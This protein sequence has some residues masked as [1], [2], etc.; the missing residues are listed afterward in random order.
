MFALSARFSTSPFFA[1]TSP[2]VRGSVFSAMAQKIYEDAV[3]L[4]EI[5]NC[6]F[7]L[8]QGC[9]LL[10]FYYQTSRP[11][12]TSWM[13]IGTCC[14]IAIELGLNKLDE[15]I[16]FAPQDAQ[17]TSI[18]EWSQKEEKRR[19]WWLVWE[20]DVFSST[21]LR[22]P[23]TID[24]SQMQVLLPVSDAN[25]LANN[26]VASAAFPSDPLSAWGTLNDTP[27]QDERAWFLVSSY[28]M[29]TA[30]DISQRHDT[31]IQDRA[32][33]AATLDCFSLLL[34]SSFH[35]SSGSLTFN[36]R[37]FSSS[38]WIISTVFMLNT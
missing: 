27:N 21:I 3:R 16:I 26:P 12:T 7:S 11:S 20:L 35:L 2:K 8:L 6:T 1:D 19:A 31:C 37:N 10:A 36:E 22:R 9:I 24:K 23:H 18:M 17:W 15:S 28:L 4:N 38:N 34:P 13:L 25:W 29:A 32:N 14:R 33:F 30:H 5:E